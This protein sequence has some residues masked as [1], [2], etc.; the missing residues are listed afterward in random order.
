[1]QCP[2]DRSETRRRA[3]D[4]AGVTDTSASSSRP[5]DSFFGVIYT[6]G[7]KKISEHGGLA[8][9]DTNVM[10]LV[11]NPRLARATVSDAASLQAVGMEGTQLLPGL[12]S[13]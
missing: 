7:R 10:L 12:N 8:H 1:L 9:D 3:H 5:S 2:A 4:Q 13:R 6:G 11:A